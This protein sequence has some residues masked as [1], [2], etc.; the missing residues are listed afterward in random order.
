[1]VVTLEEAMKEAAEDHG[2]L[3][4]LIVLA[5][6]LENRFDIVEDKL[7]ELLARRRRYG[8]PPE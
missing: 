2:P 6:A 3:R 4:V 5:I 7:D 1:M 8:V